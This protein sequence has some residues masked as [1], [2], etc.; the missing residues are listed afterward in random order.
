[1][2]GWVKALFVL[3]VFYLLWI[4]FY[5]I[6][7]SEFL[8]GGT[9]SGWYFSQNAPYC[10]TQKRFLGKH[11]G[12]VAAGSFLLAL[13]GFI[14]LVY[15]LL[16][17]NPGKE[18]TGAAAC[19]QKFCACICCLCVG[20]LFDWLNTGAY[21]WINMAG[22]TYCTSALDAL[23]LRL[24]N[25]AASGI[26]YVLSIVYAVLIRGAITALTVFIS[27]LLIQN[28]TFYKSTIQDSSLLLVVIGLVAFSV[29]CFFMGVYSDSMESIYMTYLMD[30]DAGAMEATALK[31]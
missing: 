21:T 27:Y 23:A 8:I 16:A 4:V 26:L 24:H 20:K 3:H 11:M 29:S 15:T 12:S 10:D 18:H 17:P 28:I 25:A 14:K 9:A 30:V 5:M 19:W 1:M 2:S 22:D 7:S 13:I 31:L 6:S